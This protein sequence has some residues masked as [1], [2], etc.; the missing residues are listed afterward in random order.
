MTQKEGI[1]PLSKNIHFQR[2]QLRVSDSSGKPE[3]CRQ[4]SVVGLAADSATLRLVLRVSGG[5]PTP[6]VFD[7]LTL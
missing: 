1:L 4:R 2:Y 3:V 5:T 7:L 6:A